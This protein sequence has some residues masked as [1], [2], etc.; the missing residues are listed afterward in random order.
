V[1]QPEKVT[2][3]NQDWTTGYDLLS[4]S[5]FF[6]VFIFQ[7]PYFLTLAPPSAGLCSFFG[8]FPE[9]REEMADILPD[10]AEGRDQQ[11]RDPG[12]E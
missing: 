7:R 1:V 12:R 10:Q 9:T 6:N 3:L 4:T 5:F 2:T 8:N 11:Q